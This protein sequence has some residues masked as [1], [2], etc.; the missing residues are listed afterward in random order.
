MSIERVDVASLVAP[1]G[2]AH[3]V[4]LEGPSSLVFLAGQTSLDASGTIVGDTVVGQFEQALSNL[5]AAL[6]AAGG[7]PADLVSMTIYAVDLGAYRAEAR[8]I[9]SIW[10]RLAG[11]HYPAMAAV[12]VVRLWD[13][14]ALVE[15]QAIAALATGQPSPTGQPALDE[16]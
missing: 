13:D 9:G 1:R 14:T 3:A 7:E 8:A 15:L 6:S 11:D 10:R 5:L 12:G 2:F 4:R 16:A